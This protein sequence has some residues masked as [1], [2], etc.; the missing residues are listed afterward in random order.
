MPEINEFY[1]NLHD[2]PLSQG[3]RRFLQETV[4]GHLIDGV[5]T[6]SCSGETTT[7]IEPATG[8]P[9]TRIAVGGVADINLAVEAATR[10]YEDGRWWHLAPGERER[11]LRRLA[12]LYRE[13]CD[14]LMDLDILEGGATR[15]YSQFL[16][17]IAIDI[18]NY[19]AGWPTKIEG[20]IAPTAPGMVV[21]E[22]REPIGV[23]G[24]ITPW[25]G[26]STI[27]LSIIPALAC[28]NSVVLKPA[29]QT[30]L[31]ALLVCRLC[32]EAGIPPGVI[33]LVQGY[34]HT[35][36]NALVEHPGVHAISFTGSVETGRKIQ[37][38]AAATLKRVTLELG[39]KSANIIFDDADLEKAVPMSAAAIWSHSGQICIAGSRLLLQRSI[40]DEVI[41]RLVAQ[42][43]SL[44]L[45]S[46]FDSETN[47]G[48][49]V[50]QVQLDRVCRYV[51]AG[52]AE[53]AT[54]ALGGEKGEGQGFFHQPTIFTNVNNQ[55]TIA[56]EEIFGPVVVVIPFDTEEE[57]YAI[58]N[59]SEYGLASGIWTTNLS[60]AHRAVQRLR[61]GTVWVNTYLQ[62]EPGVSYGGIKQSGVGRNLGHS[63]IEELT[64]VKSAWFNIG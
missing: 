61:A 27:P 9:F 26:P 8:Q 48:P 59:A 1:N 52:I 15:G 36:G 3:T 11:C 32:L 46:G 2:Y 12:E 10:A 57:A 50:S 41:E 31:A 30:P 64:Q 40:H 20:S 47:V 53:G 13:N 62:V 23:C 16:V 6:P 39:G 44:K 33:N 63:S 58:A 43:R 14:I 18:I 7:L 38:T 42:S 56:Q 4:Q 54:L 35:A 25:N 22:I 51:K 24:V 45:G 55:M 37:T 17:E 60:R 28:G 21:Q 34:G 19:Y 49:L 29:E 5:L